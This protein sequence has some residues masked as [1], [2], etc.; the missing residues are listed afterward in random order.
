MCWVDV[1][2][3]SDCSESETCGRNI[4]ENNKKLSDKLILDAQDFLSKKEVGL[5]GPKKVEIKK[6]RKIEEYDIRKR[7]NEN[8]LKI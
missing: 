2:G 5:S 1:S 6:I 3:L 8:I 7:H 4:L